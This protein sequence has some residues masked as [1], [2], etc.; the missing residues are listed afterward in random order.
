MASVSD[1]IATLGGAAE[2]AKARGKPYSTVASWKARNS[3]PL[4]EWSG[5]L[6][7]ARER[8]VENV[9]YERLISLHTDQRVAS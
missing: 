6:D 7:L 1:L 8:G 2:V 3:I 9:S 5:L 4:D